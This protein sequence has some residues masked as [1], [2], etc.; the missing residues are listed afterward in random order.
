MI[1]EHSFKIS[2]ISR[3]IYWPMDNVMY[4]CLHPSSGDL[5]FVQKNQVAFVQE[6][7]PASSFAS[8]G[9]VTKNGRDPLFLLWFPRLRGSKNLIWWGQTSNAALFHGSTQMPPFKPVYFRAKKQIEQERT[10]MCFFNFITLINGITRKAKS[11]LHHQ[12]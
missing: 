2:I 4:I 1:L 12:L 9:A 11:Y 7:C 10:M 5:L 3:C 6:T 8:F